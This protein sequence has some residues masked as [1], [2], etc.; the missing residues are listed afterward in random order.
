VAPRRPPATSG[1]LLE[2]ARRAVGGQAVVVDW[3]V[4]DLALVAGQLHSPVGALDATL[5]AF[6]YRHVVV[7]DAV[8]G[9]H[10]LQAPPG[11]LRDLLD[12]VIGASTPPAPPERDE[13]PEVAAAQ[14]ALDEAIGPRSGPAAVA[15][16]DPIAMLEQAAALLTQS[17]VPLAVVIDDAHL[18]F[19]DAADPATRRAIAHLRRC[20]ENRRMHPGA[21]IGATGALRDGLVL[22]EVASRARALELLPHAELHRVDAGLPD[23]DERRTGWAV[24]FQAARL[25]VPASETIDHWAQVGDVPLGQMS[26]VIYDG[27]RHRLDLADAPEVLR[28]YHRGP[29]SPGWE[30]LGPD[31]LARVLAQARAALIGQDDAIDRVGGRIV[32]GVFGPRVPGEPVAVLVLTGPSGTGKTLLS[33]ILA[34]AILG[35]DRNLIRYDMN[36]FA[37]ETSIRRFIGAEAGYV[38]YEE[39]GQLV[40]DLLD[41]PGCIALFDEFDKAPPE[42]TRVMLQLIEEGRISDGLGRTADASGAVLVFATNFGVN[43]A[44]DGMTPDESSAYYERAIVE[45]Y[46]PSGPGGDTHNAAVGKPFLGRLLDIGEIIGFRPITPPMMQAVAA[47]AA[48]ELEQSFQQRGI[49]VTI[50]ADAV[51]ALAASRVTD[52]RELEHY[53]ARAVRRQVRPIVAAVAHHRLAQ[54]HDDTPLHLTVVDGKPAVHAMPADRQSAPA[55]A[56]R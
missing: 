51:G 32:E 29:H 33:R 17:T 34:R 7:F 52:A 15:A 24:S 1:W 56:R 6:G 23:L 9:G 44:P 40:N 21:E 37:D 28:H 45:H 31:L 50:D 14:D 26:S 10:S 55:D 20:V 35:D 22:L 3:P 54:Y 2:T 12:D 5:R 47:R 13:D 4:H 43:T 38:G 49:A 53:G 18:V 25:A 30:I 27:R 36:A 39:G 11:Q 16:L 8:R 48:R 19:H 46:N 42:I 41:H